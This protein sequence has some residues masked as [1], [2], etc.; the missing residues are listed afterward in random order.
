M[1]EL[2]CAGEAAV[3]GVEARFQLA[4]R[5]VERRALKARFGRGG[6]RRDRLEDL[7]QP[8][9]LLAQRRALGPEVRV[10]AI[11]ERLSGETFIE[12]I[13]RVKISMLAIPSSAAT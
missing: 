6:A 4:A 7:Q 9:V 1:R 8:A 3:F 12:R 10:D 13:R 5:A 2:R 11:P